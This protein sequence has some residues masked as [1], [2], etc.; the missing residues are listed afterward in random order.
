MII[1]ND[2]KL[3]INKKGEKR[4]LYR[5]KCTSCGADR[6][7]KR[8]N[9]NTVSKCRSCS[10]SGIKDANKYINVDF[11][12][13]IQ[14]DKSKSYRTTCVEC[15]EDK[16]YVRKKDA[17]KP[18]LSCAA[19]MRHKNMC[20]TIKQRLKDKMSKPLSEEVKQK[21]STTLT[22]KTFREYE[23]MSEESKIKI[24]CT[25]Q[26][27]DVD[28]FKGYL[29]PESQK[30][31]V[32]FRREGLRDQCFS[33][34]NHTCDLYG[35]RGD[36]L[37]AHHLDSWHSNEDKRFALDN[38]VCMSKA[39]H[40][41]FH[42]KYGNKNNTK[43]QYEEF[44][45][46]ID[47]YKQTKQDLYIVAGCP[48]SGKSWVCEQLMDKF[49]YVSYDNVNKNYHVYELLKNN[50]KP[51]LYDPTIKVSTFTKRYGH[52]FN[53][54]LIV[55]VEDKTTIDQRMTARGGKVTNTIERRI[56]RM[57]NLSKKCEF[58]GTS[59]EVLEYL[60]K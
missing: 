5:H 28:E 41:T 3:I 36:E 12:D 47:N 49:S 52:L 11:N 35:V 27:I 25:K 37:N 46:E 55:I 6:G 21:I 4:Y 51:L 19:K 42:K 32:R 59:S 15:L 48:A 22:G 26:G 44:K 58:S 17:L 18:C 13:F 24:S 50:S 7:Y 60:K 45:K 54:R 16:G 43:I 9:T 33:N 34:A 1:L 39:A 14:N 56:K 20:P 10:K 38:L 23:P 2:K 57:N 53:I 8:K 40:K 30:E 31:R 29:T